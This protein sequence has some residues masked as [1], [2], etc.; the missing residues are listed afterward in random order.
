M[1]AVDTVKDLAKLVQQLDNIEIVQKVIQL[2]SDLMEL[3]GTVQDLRDENRD[4]KKQLEAPEDLMFR[5]NLL[6]RSASVTSDPGPFCSCCYD[7]DGKL[8][9]MHGST[10]EGYRCPTCGQKIHTRDS[11]AIQ[12]A[13]FQ[14]LQEQQ[15]HLG[16]G[17]G[18]EA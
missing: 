7:S 17:E 11:R 4:L 2:Q 5:D 9:H 12:D 10:H 16:L 18:W 8:I 15:K 1:G 14:K 6:W 3:Q 13:E